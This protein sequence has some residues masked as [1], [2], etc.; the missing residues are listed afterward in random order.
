MKRILVTGG[1]GFIGNHLCRELLSADCRVICLDNFSSGRRENVADLAGNKSFCLIEWDIIRPLSIAGEIDEIYNLA[2]IASPVGYQKKPIETM[3]ACSVG[4]KNVLDLTQEKEARFLQ[5]ST[6]EVYGDPREHPQRESY[7][8]NVNPV[9]PRSCYDE[10][11]RFAESLIFN[12]HS[13]GLNTKIVRI[14]NTYGPRMHPDDG[15][16]IS[17]FLSQAL[18]GRP[19][20]VYG[21][22]RQT[23]SFCYVSDMVSGLIA[24]MEGSVFGPINLG[25]PNEFTIL[26]LATL[27]KELTGSSSE[28]IFMGLPVDDPVKRR[29][30][31]SQAQKELGWTPQVSLAKGLEL[32]LPY[33][34]ETL[35]L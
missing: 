27:V 33:F 29:P 10:G 17:N 35:S 5:A 16:V 9:G 19:L 13:I 3:L 23:R 24:M 7:W 12:Y 20:T 28:I 32:S 8:G 6:S 1:A 22:G 4:V 30:D 26:E 31:I 34:K 25:N 14:F 21:D 15:R 2:C 11:K 18:S